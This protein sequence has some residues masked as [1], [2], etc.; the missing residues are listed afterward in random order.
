MIEAMLAMCTECFSLWISPKDSTDPLDSIRYRSSII[1]C[2]TPS[3]CTAI[4]IYVRPCEQWQCEWN[5]RQNCHYLSV[6]SKV[7]NSVPK[8]RNKLFSLGPEQFI[9]CMRAPRNKHF[10]NVLHVCDVMF[11][12]IAWYEL[13]VGVRETQNYV[14]G[15]WAKVAAALVY[16][17]VM[18]S[19]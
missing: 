8:H 12:R 10:S 3:N 15:Y 16:C 11:I 18:L 7:A 1:K 4:C 2:T 14:I 13:F 17:S 5:S 9:V 6:C 19:K